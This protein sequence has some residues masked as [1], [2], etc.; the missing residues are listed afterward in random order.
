MYHILERLE[1]LCRERAILPTPK[2]EVTFK[3][4]ADLIQRALRNDVSQSTEKEE[5]P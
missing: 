5:S 4:L 3:E 1:S 2:Q